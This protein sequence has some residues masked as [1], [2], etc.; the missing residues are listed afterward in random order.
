MRGSHRGRI[1]VTVEGAGELGPG[2]N[3]IALHGPDS[4]RSS[5]PVCALHLEQSGTECMVETPSGRER[6]CGLCIAISYV[7]VKLD[8]A[9]CTNEDKTDASPGT[10]TGGLCGTGSRC[11]SRAK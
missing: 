6:A 1:G 3:P 2:T 7:T 9:L 5:W 11:S 10:V 8:S 4:P